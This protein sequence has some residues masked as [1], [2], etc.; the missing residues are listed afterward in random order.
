MQVDFVHC[1]DWYLPVGNEVHDVL[2]KHKL[3]VCSH[4]EGEDWEAF[5][6]KAIQ[7]GLRIQVFDITGKTSAASILKGDKSTMKFS[8]TEGKPEVAEDDGFFPVPP[9]EAPFP[10]IGDQA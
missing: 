8:H 6:T 5:K 9:E 4:R 2:G 1:S 7:A 3:P 10:V